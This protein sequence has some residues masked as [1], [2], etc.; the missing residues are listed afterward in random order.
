MSRYFVRSGKPLFV[1][2]PLWEDYES[3]RRDL[4][5]SDHLASFTGLLDM[6]GEPIMRA[7]NPMGFNCRL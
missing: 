5:V 6:R 2:T 4:I 7:P 1:E 3:Q